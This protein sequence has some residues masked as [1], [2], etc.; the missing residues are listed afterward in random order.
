[1]CA[2]TIAELQSGLSQ[3]NYRL[4]SDWLKS[5]PYWDISREAAG[6][7]GVERKTAAEAGRTLHV[8]DC[9]IAACAREQDAIVLTRN[10]RDFETMKDIRLMSLR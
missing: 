3:K 2:I 10:T 8:S 6:Q 4:F 1:M 7:A 5:L 9:L